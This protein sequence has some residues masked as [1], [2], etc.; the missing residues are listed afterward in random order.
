MQVIE[1]EVQKALEKLKMVSRRI[2]MIAEKDRGR[3]RKLI[4]LL[5]Q[6]IK[7]PHRYYF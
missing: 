5:K 7:K 1:T 2:K 4:K 6:W 3:V